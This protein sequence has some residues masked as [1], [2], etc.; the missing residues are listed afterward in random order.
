MKG[1][2]IMTNVKES[3]IS[4][5][6]PNRFKKEVMPFGL[7]FAEHDD[8]DTEIKDSPAP[9]IVNSRTPCGLTDMKT[10]DYM[11]DD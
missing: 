5:E 11:N 7:R 2:E 6:F 9:K 10:W 3:V 8:I 1:G 4:K